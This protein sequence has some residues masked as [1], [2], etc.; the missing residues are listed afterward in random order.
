LSHGIGMDGQSAAATRALS[1]IPFSQSVVPSMVDG[2]V[3]LVTGE[4]LVALFAAGKRIL[5]KG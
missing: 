2:L 5:R 1:V 3:G 4:V